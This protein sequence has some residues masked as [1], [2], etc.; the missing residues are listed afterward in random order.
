MNMSVKEANREKNIVEG[1]V[2]DGKKKYLSN[3]FVIITLRAIVHSLCLEDKSIMAKYKLANRDKD[4]ISALTESK[5]LNEDEISSLILEAREYWINVRRS[6]IK[7]LSSRTLH[8]VA[9][10]INNDDAY[11]DYLKRYM[12][13]REEDN[14]DKLL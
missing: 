1:Y 2:K 12:T 4:Y 7:D 6:I 13:N 8:E 5:N 9:V 11:K 10:I 14:N 3:T